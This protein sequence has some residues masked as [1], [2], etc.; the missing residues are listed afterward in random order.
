MSYQV[1]IIVVTYHSSQEIAACLRSI[2]EQEGVALELIL[3]DNASADG[4]YKAIDRFFSTTSLKVPNTT[5]VRHSDN[6]GYPRAVN[7]AA[8]LAKGKYLFLLNPDAKFT[9]KTDLAQLV[10]FAERHPAMG[11]L[12]PKVLN[13][14]GKESKP[15]DAYPNQRVVGFDDRGLAGKIAWLIG[16]ALLIPRAVFEQEKGFDEETFL[17]GDEPDFCLRL[18]QKGYH[19]LQEAS[20]FVEHIG[21]ASADTLLSYDKKRLKTKARYQFCQRYYDPVRVNALI[22]RDYRRAQ[23]RYQ[24]TS[25]LSAIFPGLRKKLPGYAAVRDVAA[26]YLKV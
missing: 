20:V 8:R 2:A 12:G 14:A 5:L 23:R 16:A 17:Y 7:Q 11:V 3:W 21:G 1:S 4:T 19:I 22:G 24:V 15:R 10:A 13:P 26:E 18:R 9:Q 6:I 25:I